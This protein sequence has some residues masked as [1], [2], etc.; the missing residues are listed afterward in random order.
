VIG[1][2]IGCGLR[3]SETVNLRVDQLQLRERHWVI[4]DLVGK[5]GRLRTLPVPAWSKGLVDAWLRNSRVTEGRVFRRVS[6]SCT[7]EY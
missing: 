1:L 2:L 6:Y 3:R 7:T 5:G 4:V